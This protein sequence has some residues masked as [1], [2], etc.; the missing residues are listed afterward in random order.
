MKKITKICA[1]L[2]LALSLFLIGTAGTAK[3]Q[4]YYYGYQNDPVYQQRLQQILNL[5]QQAQQMLAQLQYDYGYG[6]V[7]GAYTYNYGYNYGNTYNYSSQGPEISSL[8]SY[9]GYVGSSV[10]VYGRN[11]TNYGGQPTV[12][13]ENQSGNRWQLFP[14][15]GYNDTYLRVSVNTG[16][17][18]NYGNTYCGQTLY[19]GAYNLYVE[20]NGRQSNKVTYNITGTNYGSYSGSNYCNYNTDPYCFNNNYTYTSGEVTSPKSNEVYNISNYI[21]IQWTY[22]GGNT[23]ELRLKTTSGSDCKI[24]EVSASS[25]YYSFRP[26]GSNCYGLVTQN[27]PGPFYIEVR[28]ATGTYNS[29]DPYN[30]NNSRQSGFFRIVE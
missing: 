19:S 27:D 6:T 14:Q 18:Q 2:A 13:L 24:E 26:I 29:N 11:F 5:I 9:S 15:S 10:D 30:L 16:N 7:A 4:T 20:T 12:W 23:V 25:G 3:A 22:F 28:I 21:P 17:C 1:G 8:S